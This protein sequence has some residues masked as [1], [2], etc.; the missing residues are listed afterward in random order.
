MAFWSTKAAISETRKDR[1]KNYYGEPI[2]THLRSF[3][4]YHPGPPTASPSPRLGV[5]TTPKTPIAII[6]G[7]GK[8]SYELQIWPEQ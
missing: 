1:E 4:R 8:E 6:S 2:G 7:T 5:C 3:E